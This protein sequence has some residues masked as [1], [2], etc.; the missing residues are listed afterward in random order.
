MLEGILTSPGLPIHRVQSGQKNG[1]TSVHYETRFFTGDDAAR[2][3]TDK[4]ENA[5][6]CY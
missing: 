1:K 4:V 3:C 5:S 2:G 6:W